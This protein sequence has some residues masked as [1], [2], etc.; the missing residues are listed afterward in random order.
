MSQLTLFSVN[1][2]QDG[3]NW[4]LYAWGISSSNSFR[5]PTDSLKACELLQ[6]DWICGYG[7]HLWSFCFYGQI[8]NYDEG[9][10][11]LVPKDHWAHRNASNKS[12]CFSETIRNN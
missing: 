12:I 10:L 11:I 6:K 1:I 9:E 7:V 8:L 2:I 3:S 5:S 4:D